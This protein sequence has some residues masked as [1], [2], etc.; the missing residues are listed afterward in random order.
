MPWKGV[1]PI[2]AGVSDDKTPGRDVERILHGVDITKLAH[3]DLAGRHGMDICA[4]QF[5][6][7]GL[8]HVENIDHLQDDVAGG[9]FFTSAGEEWLI[10]IGWSVTTSKR[11]CGDLCRF[12]CGFDS[13]YCLRND[14]VNRNNPVA[15]GIEEHLLD[16]VRR[17][18]KAGQGVV[19][20]QV[21]IPL[22][23]ARIHA[24]K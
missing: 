12:L 18:S 9:V 13:R 2:R 6:G 3:H 22:T 24:G 19:T 8:I 20:D 23:A 7:Q 11:T 14:L 16:I 1:R 10:G 5:N 17:R 4:D 15:L 21:R